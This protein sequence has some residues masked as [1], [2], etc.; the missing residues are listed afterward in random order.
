[1]SK[2]KKLRDALA[3]YNA[4]NEFKVG[5]IVKWKPG[6]KNRL[7]PAQD[8]LVIVAG[9]FSGDTIPDGIDAGVPSSPI[10]REPIDL[11]IAMIDPDDSEFMLYRINSARMMV[12]DN[13]AA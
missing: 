7:H 3:V 4:Q 10:F 6:M 12:V 1:M 11:Q 5:D 2:I 13:A 8:E 9:L